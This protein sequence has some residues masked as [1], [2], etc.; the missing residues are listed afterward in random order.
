MFAVVIFASP[1]GSRESGMIS[2]SVAGGEEREHVRPTRG[3]GAGGRFIRMRRRRTAVDRWRAYALAVAAAVATAAVG[4]VVAAEPASTDTRSVFEAGSYLLADVNQG[5]T[6]PFAHAVR[7]NP[8]QRRVLMVGDSTL[9][10]VRNVTESQQ[11]F[12]G[13]QPIL[14]AEGCRRLVW[15]SCWSNSDF[16]VPST[17]EEAILGTPGHLDVVVVMSG[18]NDWNDPF[19]SFVDTIMEAARTKGAQRVIWLTLSTGTPPGSS[20]SAIRVFAENTRM[21]WESAPRHPDLVVADWRTYN[22]R[23]IGWMS[24]DGVHLERR[25][26]FGLADYISRWIAHLEGRECPAPLDPGAVRQDPCPSPNTMTRV[27]DV[28][29]LY[30]V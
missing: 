16:R 23:A 17:V 2:S 1:V 28:R 9:A 14:D 25:G 10:A 26:A 8:P 30:G 21:L 18:Y 12:V 15:P 7:L 19:G 11:L 20:A 4:R 6:G 13:F 3:R 22:G 24:D 5:A 29:G 27:P